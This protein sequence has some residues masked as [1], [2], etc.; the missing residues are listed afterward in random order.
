MKNHRVIITDKIPNQTINLKKGETLSYIA[1]INKGWEKKKTLTF[2]F[3]EKNATLNFLTII[4]GKK[5]EKFPFETISIH[6][7]PS[8]KAHY[9]TRA[10]LFDKS[11]IDYKGFL[12]IKKKGQN[13]DAYLEHHTLMLS[14][15]T[16][17]HTVPCLEIEADEVKAGHA[18]TIG[19]VDNDLLFYLNSRGINKKEGQAMLIKGFLESDISKIPDKE[20][21]SYITNKIKDIIHD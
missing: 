21:Q 12:K 15:K 13:T 6:E 10:V 16:K 3:E 8:T 19:R 14:D 17:T 5:E 9:T 1:I 18:A 11:E 7:T 20:A 2:N 4:V